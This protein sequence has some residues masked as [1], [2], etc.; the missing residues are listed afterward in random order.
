[1]RQALLF[2]VLLV[3]GGAVA[4]EFFPIPVIIGD[5]IFDLTV[6]V[7]SSAGPLRSVSCHACSRREDAEWIVEHLMA[8]SPI[9][10]TTAEPFDGQPLTV[11]VPFTVRVSPCGR[12]LRRSQHGYL[13]VLAQLNDGR[14]IGKRVEIPDIRLASAV[15]VSLP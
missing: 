5:G 8:E 6:H 1:M 2:G 10:S 4:W 11:P 9:W 14:R 12:E 15:T 7:S 13:V 3:A